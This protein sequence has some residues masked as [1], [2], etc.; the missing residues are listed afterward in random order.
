MLSKHSAVYTQQLSVSE[1]GFAATHPTNFTK[2]QHSKVSL[3]VCTGMP[4]SV[5]D[6]FT[7]IAPNLHS[8]NLVLCRLSCTNK[9][10][11]DLAYACHKLS[12][13]DPRNVR[14][15][16]QTLHSVIN[17]S[18]HLTMLNISE[19]FE[20]SDKTL[21]LLRYYSRKIQWLA[22]NRS[23]RITAGKLVDTLEKFSTHVCNR[24]QWNS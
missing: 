5:L 19:C 16:D 20:L 1:P 21:E 7:R 12:A 4:E 10:V 11:T 2:R 17:F 18:K 24:M 22:I 3:G 8:S 15:N 9:S 23:Y 13:I 6:E 14:V